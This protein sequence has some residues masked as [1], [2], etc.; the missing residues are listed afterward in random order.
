MTQTKVNAVSRARTPFKNEPLT[1]FSKP[2][3]REAQAKALEQVKS[4]LGQTQPLLIGGQK[5]FNDETFAS[6]NP[7]RPD[8]VIGY[9][10]RA[11]FEQVDHA[12]KNAA[13]AFES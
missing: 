11:T 4:E 8:E 1:D 3:N 5:I 7:S 12:V 13:A 9:F 10:A 6:I 2:K